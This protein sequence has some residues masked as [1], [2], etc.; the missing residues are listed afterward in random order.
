MGGCHSP[1]LVSYRCALGG[2]L[3]VHMNITTITTIVVV[4]IAVADLHILTRSRES[5]AAAAGSKGRNK[6][7]RVTRETQG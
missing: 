7:E 2:V 3:C 1:L 4:V 5:A 6:G